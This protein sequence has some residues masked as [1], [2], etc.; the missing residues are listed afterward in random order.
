MSARPAALMG[1]YPGP[2]PWTPTRRNSRPSG[3]CNGRSRRVQ[4]HR[5]A[6]ATEQQPGID[7]P[8]PISAAKG[9]STT[10]SGRTST[11]ASDASRIGTGGASSARDPAWCDHP[12][13]RNRKAELDLVP[14]RSVRFDDSLVRGKRWRR[15]APHCISAAF[16]SNS[17]RPIVQ[18]DFQDLKMSRQ[19]GDRI[20]MHRMDL[21]RRFQPIQTV[22]NLG[23]LVLDPFIHR[24]SP[25]RRKQVHLNITPDLSRCRKKT[26]AR[27]SESNAS[28]QRLNTKVSTDHG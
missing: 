28:L 9:S 26:P 15:E 23:E 21:Y 24:R 27:F 25:S 11:P 1:S 3:T 20:G 18:E 4:T 22:P 19:D 8:V 12:P 2:R 7:P 16:H 5:R 6:R 10:C 13:E 17:R 14:M